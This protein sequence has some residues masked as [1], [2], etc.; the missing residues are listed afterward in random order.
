MVLGLGVFRDFRVWWFCGLGVLKF[1][2]FRVVRV[3]SF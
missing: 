3:C 1:R 2:V